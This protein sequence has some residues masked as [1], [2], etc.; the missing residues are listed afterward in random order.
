[1]FLK[2]LLISVVIYTLHST[3]YAGS[4]FDNDPQVLAKKLDYS[5]ESLV[6]NGWSIKNEDGDELTPDVIKKGKTSTVILTPPPE[7]NKYS[8]SYKVSENHDDLSYVHFDISIL[9]T[10]AKH[11]KAPTTRFIFKS[12]Q[13]H[14]ENKTRFNQSLHEITNKWTSAKDVHG[15]TAVAINIANVLFLS[16]I[17]KESN[18]VAAE[19]ARTLSSN[20]YKTTAALVTTFGLS[21]TLIEE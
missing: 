17:L 21:R 19:K 4:T 2:G 9:R 15:N 20:L 3:V 6:F 18:G 13:T 10:I 16:S 8:L 1:M 12:S 5:L 7:K 11:W 14:L